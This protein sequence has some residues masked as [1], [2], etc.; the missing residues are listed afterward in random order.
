MTTPA[1]QE[2][3]RSQQQLGRVR[4]Q[5]EA[6]LQQ[7]GDLLDRRK[8]QTEL[9]PEVPPEKH[10]ERLQVLRSERERQLRMQT[11]AVRLL[12]LGDQLLEHVTPSAAEHKSW[13]SLNSRSREVGRREREQQQREESMERILPEELRNV[14]QAHPPS[15]LQQRM[16]LVAE[17]VERVTGEMLRS[18]PA[19]ASAVRASAAVSAGQD[20]GQRAALQYERA[21]MAARQDK[22]AQ[23]EAVAMAKDLC[24]EPSRLANAIHGYSVPGSAA[25]AA[26]FLRPPGTEDRT[27]S[28]GAVPRASSSASAAAAPT[29]GT[30]GRRR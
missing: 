22:A 19:S 20:A 9:P 1:E 18:G 5:L 23:A 30:G 11:L 10:L 15:G 4:G 2:S 25:A 27:S 21:C 12:K 24:Y 17:E 3:T 28:V 7:R 29:A 8:R 16:L 6:L 13:Q 14:A 26:A